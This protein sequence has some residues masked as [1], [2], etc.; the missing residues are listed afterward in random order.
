M[1]IAQ[2]LMQANN[3]VA[4]TK[5]VNQVLVKQFGINVRLA[6]NHPGQVPASESRVERRDW[7]HD[8]HVIELTSLRPHFGSDRAQESAHA[9]GRR[10]AL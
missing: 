8:F 5:E 7:K 4:N 9:L 1:V 3:T 6:A 10:K 2:N